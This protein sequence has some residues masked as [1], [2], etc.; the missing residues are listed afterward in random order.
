MKRKYMRHI[1]PLLLVG[2]LCC[3]TASA[4]N[5]L[6]SKKVQP[7]LRLGIGPDNARGSKVEADATF[8][9]IGGV[10]FYMPIGSDG[11]F[12]GGELG[13]RSRGFDDW[14]NEEPVHTH[15]AYL[16]PQLGWHFTLSSHLDMALRPHFGLFGSVDFAGDTS[17]DGSDLDVGIAP[18]I[19]F[20]WKK[21]GFDMEYRHGF[22]DF[23]VDKVQANKFM[24]SFMY[25][26]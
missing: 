22:C 5:S 12:W 6:T 19:T 17:S 26:F 7:Y 15:G 21:F 8:G 18:G 11:L 1:L 14:F 20:W 16:M 25:A 9:Y 10:G 23:Y 24:F 13:L 3:G 2:A 4:Q